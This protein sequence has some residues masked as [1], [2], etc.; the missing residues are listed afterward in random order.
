[1]KNRVD[2][3]DDDIVVQQKEKPTKKLQ[4]FSIFLLG[5]SYSFYLSVPDLFIVGLAVKLVGC[6][7]NGTQG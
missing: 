7:V 3:G 5:K 1:L 2:E 4:W 6:S